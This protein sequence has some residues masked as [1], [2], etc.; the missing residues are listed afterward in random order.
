MYLEDFQNYGYAVIRQ[1]A[2]PKVA[3]R[4]A[5]VIAGMSFVLDR[6]RHA[7]HLC[8]PCLPI[9][10]L[11]PPSAAPQVETETS[12]AATAV[13]ALLESARRASVGPE[14]VRTIHWSRRVGVLGRTRCGR[15]TSE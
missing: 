13:L 15:T 14:Q 9:L 3:A 6:H 8:G 4:T 7:R 12:A 1:L 5:Y 11:R 10:L 2:P